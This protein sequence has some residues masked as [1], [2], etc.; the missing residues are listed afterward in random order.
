MWFD[1][2]LLLYLVD[3]LNNGM[4]S[5]LFLT[6]KTSR[7]IAYST[8]WIKRQ[9]VRTGVLGSD[10]FAVDYSRTGDELLAGTRMREVSLL[11]AVNATPSC[12][13]EFAIQLW[14]ADESLLLVLVIIVIDD[15]HP[16][17]SRSW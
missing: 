6:T 9:F 15:L 17:R 2:A 12:H 8:D 16:T 10:D 13:G 14:P 3:Y 4:R 1:L 7:P 11:Q 5:R